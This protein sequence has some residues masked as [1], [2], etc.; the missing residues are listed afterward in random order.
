MNT[1]KRLRRINDAYNGNGD[2]ELALFY[3]KGRWMMYVG[4]KSPVM[5]GECE[6]EHCF[7]AFKL[8]DVLSA[9]ENELL[10]NIEKLTRLWQTND[11]A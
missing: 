8:E 3:S 7:E 1:E 10:S 4:N 11:T 5:L 6:G 2:K 9:A